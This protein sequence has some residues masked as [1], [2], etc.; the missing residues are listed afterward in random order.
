LTYALGCEG[1]SGSDLASELALLGS[2]RLGVH[3]HDG[4]VVCGV[5]EDK[6]SNE[7]FFLELC[8]LPQK[9]YENEEDTSLVL[10]AVRLH[11]KHRDTT[12]TQ[13]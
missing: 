9:N 12:S 11:I 7:F 6:C 4:G 13:V 5:L 8:V 3:R 1:L 2:S 10:H